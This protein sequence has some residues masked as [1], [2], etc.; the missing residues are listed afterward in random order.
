MIYAAF[1]TK[2]GDWVDKV[3]RFRTVSPYSHVELVMPN[4]LCYSSS[5]RD[6]GVRAKALELLPEDWELVPLPFADYARIKHFYERTQGNPYDFVGAIIGQGLAAKA[7]R[8]GAYFCSEWVAESL[9]LSDP[10]R[11]SP[12]LLYNVLTDYNKVCYDNTRCVTL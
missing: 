5:P 3:I 1:Y 6:G 9:G 2:R 11:Y 12:A 10:W 8:D 4:G 7:H